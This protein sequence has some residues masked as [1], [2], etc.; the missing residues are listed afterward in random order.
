M[1]LISI[2]PPVKIEYPL[3]IIAAA[4]ADLA[5]SAHH[6]GLR[7]ITLD[8]FSDDDTRLASLDTYDVG[9][10]D[11]SGFDGDRIMQALDRI[12]RLHDA[13]LP[14]VY[15]SGLDCRPDILESI[16]SGIRLHGN[17]PEL[18]R[19]VKHPRHWQALLK[20]LDIPY[21]ETR[22]AAPAEVA[23]WLYKPSCGEGGHGIVPAEAAR[24][25][26]HGY[27]QKALTGLTCSLL[28]LASRR[29][30]FAIGI[31]TQWTDAGAQENPY[32]FGGIIN[33]PL[34]MGPWIQNILQYAQRLARKLDLCG[35]NT[36][37][38]IVHDQT[39]YVLELNPRPGASFTLYD[40]DYPGGL[41]KY[42][43]QSCQKQPLPRSKPGSHVRAM[44]IIYA[45]CDIRLP[46][47]LKWPPW[48]A[49]RPEAGSSIRQNHPVCTV[50]STGPTVGS[51]LQQLHSRVASVCQQLGQESPTTPDRNIINTGL[52]TSQP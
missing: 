25:R 44:Q 35:L 26:T 42:H 9:N 34:K 45:H 5:R 51:A 1:A 28:F 47:A 48:C 33:R 49:H 18:L 15:G 24:D 17:P 38:F 40:D 36:I 39:A 3:L 30:V 32:R 2:T 19:M 50:R 37:D 22:E 23:G 10:H 8:W 41:L 21:P 20:E 4:A 29:K 43:L 16:P 31:N 13:P 12:Q 7:P 11:R 14:M 46:E 6:G 52:I 27:Y